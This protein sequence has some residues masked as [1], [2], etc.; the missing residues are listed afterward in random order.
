MT[1]TYELPYP[2]SVN[3]Y[4]RRVGWR[5]LIS[6]EGRRYRKE[7]VALLAAQRAQP[8]GGRLVMRVTVFPPDARR[9]DLDNVQKALLDAL[10]QGEAFHDDSQIDELVI[11]RGAVVPDGKTIVEI[12]EIDANGTASVPA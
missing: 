1:R 2:P 5:T 9:R 3:H 8:L 6:R 4:W 10:Q 12:T 7:V 11:K